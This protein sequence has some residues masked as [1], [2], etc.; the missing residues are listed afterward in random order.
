MKKDP[1]EKW[2]VKNRSKAIKILFPEIAAMKANA[3][4]NSPLHHPVALKLMAMHQEGIDLSSL[5]LRELGRLLDVKH[6][7]IIK[8]HKTRVL[9]YLKFLK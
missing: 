1:I 3:T 5:G 8:H 6:P 4:V 2:L 7:Q 9:N